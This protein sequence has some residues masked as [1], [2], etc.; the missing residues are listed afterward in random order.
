M[1]LQVVRVQLDQ[2]GQQIVA[3]PVF[4]FGR[5]GRAAPDVANH[6]VFGA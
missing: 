1:L 4:G 6:T 2:A 5:G 3:V